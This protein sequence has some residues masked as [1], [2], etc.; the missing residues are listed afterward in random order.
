MDYAKIASCYDKTKNVKNDLILGRQNLIKRK[1]L[2][3]IPTTAGSGAE[4]T[5][6]AVM[7]INNIKY[8]F[9]GQELIPDNFF[10]IPELI[11]KNNQK[12]KASSGMDAIAQALESMISNKSNSKSI[13]FSS[14]ALQV[15]LKNYLDYLHKP[16]KS[17]S[18]KML[19]G[20]MMAGKAINI[21]K[22]TAPHA[23]S[24]PFTSIFNI[25]HG[26]AVSLTLEKFLKFNFFHQEKAI[27]DFDLNKRYEKI[28]KIFKVKNIS[29]FELK[30]KKLKNL[31]S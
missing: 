16:N 31:Q 27:C 1:K 4:V 2:V 22:T 25:S 15:C 11:L 23:I 29:E 19:Y 24:Y 3:V 17:N 7:Y 21:S 30:L 9:E 6:N 12:L 28:F 10:L 8:S 13:L 20:S 26:H 18:S 5:S 14:N